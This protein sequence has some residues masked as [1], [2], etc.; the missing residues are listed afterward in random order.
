MTVTTSKQL[1]FVDTTES[2]LIDIQSVRQQVL[3]LNALKPHNRTL[4]KNAFCYKF[5]I[6]YWDFDRLLVQETKFTTEQFYDFREAIQ[7]YADR[8]KYP[9]A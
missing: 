4:I 6:T 3:K 7:Y 1:T 5:Q 9:P 2:G 8:E